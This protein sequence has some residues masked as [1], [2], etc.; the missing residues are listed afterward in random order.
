M[1]SAQIDPAI[2][3]RGDKKEIDDAQGLAMKGAELMAATSQS[4]MFIGKTGATVKG[5]RTKAEIQKEFN[6]Y[7]KGLENE[8]KRDL[9]KAVMRKQDRDEGMSGEEI[10]LLR[11]LIKLGF[12][13]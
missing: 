10:K 12:I 13:D 11:E 9:V 5:E 3:K 8:A 6:E 7:M 1:V 4:T 2:I